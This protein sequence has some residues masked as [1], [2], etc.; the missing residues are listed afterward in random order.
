MRRFWFACLSLSFFNAYAFSWTD[1]WLTKNQQA[2]IEMKNGQF[3]K[4]E[5][6]F[7][8]PDWRATAAYRAGNYEKAA[9]HYLALQTAFGFYNEGNAL[10]HLG[11]F[12][13]AIKAYNAALAINPKHQDALYNRKLLQDLLKK[14]KDQQGQNQ[15]GKDQQ[16]KDQQGQNQQNKNQQNQ[17]QKNQDQQNKEQQSQN[18]EAK[19]QQE[20]NQ[21]D[22][23]KQNQNQNQKDKNQ[24]GKEQQTKPT[25]PEPKA[26]D[27]MQSAEK[28]EKQQAKEQWLR[29]I[30]DDPAGLMREKFLRDHLRREEGWYQ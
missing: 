2:Q 1:L 8:N 11:K 19:K 17:N 7:Q 24:Q 21:K 15:E 12:E 27:K 18:Q 3:K 6:T 14:N 25:K 30:P 16:N 26:A 4:A 29:L 9:K 13:E 10:A 5:A 28:L 22:K 23:D 20:Q